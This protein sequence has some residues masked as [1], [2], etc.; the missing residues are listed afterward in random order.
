MTIAIIVKLLIYYI[1]YLRFIYFILLN[2]SLLYIII[3][4]FLRDIIFDPHCFG[5]RFDSRDLK[6]C[7]KFNCNQFKRQIFRLFGYFKVI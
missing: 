7:I 2:I 1:Y 6:K 4:T 5:N 3:Y